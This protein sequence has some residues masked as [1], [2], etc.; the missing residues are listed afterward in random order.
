[1][2]TKTV[3]LD[4]KTQKQV[5][6]LTKAFGFTTNKVIRTS[7]TGD[8]RGTWDYSVVFDDRV[9]FFIANGMK[10]F[11]QILDEKVKTYT[12]FAQN[13]NKIMEVLKQIEEA[14][15]KREYIGSNTLK[16]YTILDVDFVKDSKR[17]MGWFYITMKVGDEIIN[18]IETHMSYEL[19]NMACND[20]YRPNLIANHE[21]YVA[22]GIHDDKVNY[23]FNKVGYSTIEPL[24]QYIVGQFKQEKEVSFV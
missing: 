13:K 18:Y 12:G 22:G 4:T 10:Y 8:W 6:E 3:T 11:K 21:Y 20:E 19:K 16:P 17:N 9:E 7:C 14:D 23:V 24:Y 5:D 2:T 15:S 1:M